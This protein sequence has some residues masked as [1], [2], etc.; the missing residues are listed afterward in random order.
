MT[1][2]LDIVI[3]R[4]VLESCASQVLGGGFDTGALFISEYIALRGAVQPPACVTDNNT[5]HNN[6]TLSWPPQ[7]QVCMTLYSMS[8][9][10]S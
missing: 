5:H 7:V 9:S 8:R 1:Q 10:R 3:T 4:C 6:N 2:C